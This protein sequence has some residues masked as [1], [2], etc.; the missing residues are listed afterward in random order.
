[1]LDYKW[2]ACSQRCRWLEWYLWEAV[3]VRR[4]GLCRG[5]SWLH[6]V[7]KSY[8]ML[9]LEPRLFL[10]ASILSGVGFLSFLYAKSTILIF[11]DFARTSF[12]AYFSKTLYLFIS[13]VFANF[14]FNVKDIN[15]NYSLAF[16]LLS[17]VTKKFIAISLQIIQ[18]LF[19]YRFLCR[20]LIK[21]CI[22]IFNIN[23]F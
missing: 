2:E 11:S 18:T 15:Y 8:E 22:Y 5:R 16:L 1:M 13:F 17:Q 10:F 20:Y 7:T 4:Q 12:S 14:F 9:L 23:Q 6:R 3:V 19:I 21:D